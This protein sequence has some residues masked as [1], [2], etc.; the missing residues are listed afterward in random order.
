MAIFGGELGKVP[1]HVYQNK[2]PVRLVDEDAS[3]VHATAAEAP[4]KAVEIAAPP[5]SV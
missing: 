4:H 3:R 2:M 1:A 5:S